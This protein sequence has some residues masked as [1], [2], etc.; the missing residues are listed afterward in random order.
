MPRY[1]VNRV[2]DA[3]NEHGTALKGRRCLVLGAAYKPDID[4][5]RES[6]AM[7]VIALLQKK[8]ASVSY[9]DPYIPKIQH[10]TD[11]WEMSSTPDLM[12]AV[13][14]ADCVIVVTNHTVYDYAAILEKAHL[15]FDTRNAYGKIARDDR[16]V[17]RL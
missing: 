8:G 11:G 13:A 10:H 4:D 2:M 16:R 14:E 5:V 9:H 17:V 6:P 1:V 15:I 3:L 7:D 12:Q